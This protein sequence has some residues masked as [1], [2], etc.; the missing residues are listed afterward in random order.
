MVSV[1][2]PRD[3]PRDVEFPRSERGFSRTFL[4]TV[5]VMRHIFSTW[6]NPT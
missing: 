4:L 6:V 5:H 1:D 2:D 3:T